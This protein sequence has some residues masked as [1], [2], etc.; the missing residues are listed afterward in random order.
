MSPFNNDSKGNEKFRSTDEP[1]T[2]LGRQNI[3]YSITSQPGLTDVTIGLTDDT[4]TIAK[5]NAW[6]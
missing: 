6:N 3:K 5:R 4:A 1:H 2:L